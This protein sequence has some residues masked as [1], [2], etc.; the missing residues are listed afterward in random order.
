MTS[1]IHPVT[2][3]VMSE[4]PSWLEDFELRLDGWASRE[5]HSIVLVKDGEPLG[6]GMLW[7]EQ[8]HCS[9]YSLELR[10]APESETE[11]VATEIVGALLARRQQSLPVTASA[12]VGSQQDLLLSMMGAKTIQMVPP[13]TIR[14]SAVTESAHSGRFVALPASVVAAEK[15][16]EAARQMYLWTHEKWAPVQEE[17]SALIAEAL[18]VR[19]ADFEASSVVVTDM[20]E[21]R[22]LSLV[23]TDGSTAEL[24]AETTDLDEPYG[25]L[26]VESCVI[27]SLDRLRARSFEAVEFDGHVTDIHFF[28]SWIRLEPQ[29]RWFRIVELPEL[30]P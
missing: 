17:E 12:F 7:H 19:E 13:P 5:S 14:I 8:L 26:M 28:P 25:E 10:L 24:I 15:V 29:G 6:V 2:Q 21:V 1:S 4:R 27:R 3:E 22:A 11:R 16:V 18:G 30:T 20:G 9:H 23:W